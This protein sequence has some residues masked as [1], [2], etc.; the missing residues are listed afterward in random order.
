MAILLD[1]IPF[2]CQT[3]DDSDTILISASIYRQC[4]A[5]SP[6]SLLASIEPEDI[7]G[8]AS[9]SFEDTAQYTQV[10]TSASVAEIANKFAAR[11]VSF[12]IPILRDAAGA[13]WDEI[14]YGD[15]YVD[16]TIQEGSKL[17]IIGDKSG[18]R[19]PRYQ[20]LVNYWKSL[21]DPEPYQ[22]DICPNC[23]IMTT[24]GVVFGSG[25]NFVKTIQLMPKPVGKDYAGYEGVNRADG[26]IFRYRT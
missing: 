24:G 13:K 4:E 26:R 23:E 9:I 2:F 15:E 25:K 3:T 17:L 7:D 18:Q 14:V 10:I 21:A 1:Q 11:A 20:V 19:V 16:S 12:T 8:Q 22:V 5:L 6:D